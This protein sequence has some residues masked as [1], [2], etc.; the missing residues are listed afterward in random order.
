MNRFAHNYVVGA[1]SGTAVIAVAIA[2]FVLLVSMQ[3]VRDWPASGLGLHIGR[4]DGHSAVSGTATRATPRHSAPL[5]G[6]AIVAGGGAGATANATTADGPGK[7]HH[8]GGAEAGGTV[9]EGTSV[10]PPAASHSSPVRSPAS[11]SPSSAAAPPETSSGPI[12]ATGGGPV[13]AVGVPNETS[14]PPPTSPTS[15]ATTKAVGGSSGSKPVSDADSAPSAPAPAPG[16]GKAKGK[17]KGRGAGAGPAAHGAPAVHGVPAAHG[18]SG[19]GGDGLTET[20]ETPSSDPPGVPG[21]GHGKGA[22]A[23]PAVPEEAGKALGHTKPE[24]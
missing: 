6:H 16:A 13:E 7:R 21:D 23:D 17:E 14:A 1:M 11:N 2:A 20:T 10:M 3:A 9:G 12:P 4:D 22:G 15:Q 24:P 18:V 19:K 8:G 5:S